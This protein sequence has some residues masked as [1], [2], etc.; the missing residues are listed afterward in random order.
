MREALRHTLEVLAITVP[1]WL[2]AHVRADWVDRY[3][4]RSDEWRLPKGKQ[5]QDE[6][7]NRIGNDGHMR[8]VAV[9]AADA[10]QWLRAV[11]AV[12]VLRRVWVQ[13]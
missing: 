5:Q 9:Y 7:V 8:L 6:L 10:P 11:P 1:D 12:E 3:A 4:G 13:N 2:Q